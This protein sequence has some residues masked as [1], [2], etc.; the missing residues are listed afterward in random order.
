MNQ[1][2]LEINN[3]W[4]PTQ[5]LELLQHIILSNE[6]LKKILMKSRNLNMDN[7]YIGAG[8]ITQTVWNYLS[9]KPLNY[10]IKD[11]DFVY[12]D[13]QSMDYASENKVISIIKD[14]FQDLAVD[15][16]V[17]NQARVHLWYK[18]HFGYDIKPYISLESA[19]NS[20]PTTATAIGVRM[21]KNNQLY[22]YLP[23]GLNDLLSKIVRPNKKQITQDIYEG[24]VARWIENWPDLKIIP[25][26]S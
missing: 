1:E 6:I 12:F 13:H 17:K 16:D 25:W 24:K 23:F 4:N 20:W 22:I 19:I 10:G 8:C 11:I 14:L 21:L 5:Q 9:N 18:D 3:N 2:N 15:I 26:H 7:Y